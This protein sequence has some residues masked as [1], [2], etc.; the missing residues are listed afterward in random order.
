MKKIPMAVYSHAL[1]NC[2]RRDMSDVASFARPT[3]LHTNLSSGCVRSQD[4]T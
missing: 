1:P 3:R 2:G 4:R